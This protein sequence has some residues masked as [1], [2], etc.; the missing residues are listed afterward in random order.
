MV[1]KFN[2]TIFDK[3]EYKKYVK[4]ITKVDVEMKSSWWKVLVVA[5][6]ASLFNAIIHGLLPLG[7]STLPPSILVEKGLLPIAFIIYGFIYYALLGYI[8]VMIQNRLTGSKLI[9]GLKYGLFF[10]ILTFIIYFEPIPTTTTLS[11]TNMSWMLA[12]GIPYVLLGTFLGL[13]L[14]NEGKIEENIHELPSMILLLVVPVIFS[15]EDYHT[16]YYKN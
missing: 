3:R 14:A 5:F 6:L 9:K 16:Y 4:T 13:F 11:I 12:D 2:L 7:T 15:L 8:F 10:C 1:I